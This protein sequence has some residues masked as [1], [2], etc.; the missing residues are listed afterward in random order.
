MVDLRLV[1]THADDFSPL[2]PIEPSV[3]GGAK[4]AEAVLAAVTAHDFTRRH[5]VVYTGA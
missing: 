5:T 1:C 4:I 3:V 2:S